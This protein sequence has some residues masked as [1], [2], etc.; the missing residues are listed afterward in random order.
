MQISLRDA[1][2]LQ[3]LFYPYKIAPFVIQKSVDVAAVC[4]FQL[5][6]TY[7]PCGIRVGAEAGTGAGATAASCQLP[8][9][10]AV[11]SA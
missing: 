4:I 1:I 6:I 8:T 10:L 7:T 9:R 5:N 11:K 3:H 2:K